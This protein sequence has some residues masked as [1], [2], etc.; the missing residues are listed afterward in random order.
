MNKA[1]LYH[2]KITQ[3]RLIFENHP[4]TADFPN[5]FLSL[6]HILRY[7]MQM[8]GVITADIVA[9]TDV[10]QQWRDKLSAA[11]RE[12]VSDLQVIAP[13]RMELFRGDSVQIVVERFEE[14][15]RIA[16]LFR[17]G[18]KSK[19]PTES[20]M[21]WDARVSLGVGEISYRSDKILE[22]DGEAFHLSGRGLDD[23]G[24]HRLSVHTR[25]QHI[26]EEM[27]VST[28]FAD[29]I[30][31]NW[32]LPQAQVAYE[33]LLHN[34]TQKE[35]A[36]ATNKSEQTVSKLMSAAKKKLIDSYLQRYSLLI[37]REMAK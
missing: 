22:S 35:V 6:Y 17:A 14:A 5:K 34:T 3:K 9:S 16:L 31:S 7:I 1:Y 23:I 13:L 18:L 26:N 27:Q 2:L 25:W 29:D 4:K 33:I 8:I 15:L 11:I 19:T 12:V 36:F 10:P 21:L 30:V 28:A 37:M 20:T 32:T 24:K